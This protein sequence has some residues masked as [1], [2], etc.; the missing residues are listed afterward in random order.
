[1]KV[2]AAIAIASALKSEPNEHYIVP[3]SLDGDIALLIS[4]EL[5]KVGNYSK[6]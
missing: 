1:M 4:D 6:L 2:K 5:G 3:D